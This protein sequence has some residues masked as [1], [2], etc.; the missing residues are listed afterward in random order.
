MAIINHRLDLVIRLIDATTGRPVDEKNVS[1]AKDGVPIRM[2][3]KDG[4]IYYLINAGRENFELT[5]NIYGY[6][7]KKLTIDY[8]ELE[9]RIPEKL[10]WL[11]PKNALSLEGTLK[12]IKSLCAVRLVTP[13]CFVNSYDA[14]KNVITLFNPHNREMQHHLYGILDSERKSFE[15]IYLKEEDGLKTISPTEPLRRNPGVNDPIERIIPGEVF[16]D[17]RYLLRMRD[18]ADKIEV[19]VRFEADD[20]EYFQKVELHG[21]GQDELDR[22]KAFRDEGK[23]TEVETQ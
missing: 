16:E 21:A 9:E 15:K 23:E 18:D 13:G 3:E 11:L 22:E 20:R 6:E 10:I 5:L 4:G 7:V 14:R 2:I 17:G 1:F 8:G 19:L 12:G